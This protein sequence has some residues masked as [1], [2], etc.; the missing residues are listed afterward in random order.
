MSA[1]IGDQLNNIIT[2]TRD[3][4]EY[5]KFHIRLLIR[6]LFFRDISEYL[7][8]EI[9]GTFKKLLSF[10][11]INLLLIYLI[12]LKFDLVASALPFDLTI[13]MDIPIAQAIFKYLPTILTRHILGLIVF[14]YIL[15]MGFTKQQFGENKTKLI[16]I[17]LISSTYILFMFIYKMAEKEIFQH[18]FED[19]LPD[20]YVYYMDYIRNGLI[21]K[22][23]TSTGIK[24]FISIIF[25]ILSSVFWYMLWFIF[26][27][28]KVINLNIIIKNRVVIPFI[29]AIIFF[30]F[31]NVF[32]IYFIEGIEVFKRSSSS[33]IIM[34]NKIENAISKE[35]PNYVAA[36]NFASIVANDNEIPDILRFYALIKVQVLRTAILKHTNPEF[37][38]KLNDY[39][40]FITA[41]RYND[42]QKR[43][44][45]F[46]MI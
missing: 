10:W 31:I 8:D 14:C 30:I 41:W 12:A 25:L 28:V 16:K 29:K 37:K 17:F 39:M 42:N 46:R 21:A 33:R 18:V 40:P 6:A 9:E 7:N 3:G 22:D 1:S 38:I 27:V 34:F 19:S 13:K 35:N 2:Y 32:L 11:F 5:F 23:F 4:F 36:A 26:L 20:I 44:L 43:K 45:N 15:R 24:I